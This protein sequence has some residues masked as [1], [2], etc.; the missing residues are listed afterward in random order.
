MRNAENT[1][2]REIGTRRAFL[3]AAVTVSAAVALAT[4]ARAQ[5]RMQPTPACGD[6]GGP[7]PRQT[8]GPYYTPRTPLRASLVEAGMGGTR[9]VV[10]GVVLSAACTPIP[11]AILDF[12]QADDRGEYDNAGYR[13]RGH[14][15]ADDRGRYR[16]TTIVPGNYPGRTRHIHVKVAAPGRPPLTTQLYFPDEPNNRRDGLFVPE[17]V[18]KVRERRQDGVAGAFDF[19]LDV[20][21]S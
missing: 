8:E 16:L 2:M 3:R 21:S 4:D 5:S 17:L 1:R 11:N 9:L 18:V 19:V 15:L 20:R 6:S 10:E 14:Q 13:L 12:W 7:T